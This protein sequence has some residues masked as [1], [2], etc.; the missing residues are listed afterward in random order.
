MTGGAENGTSPPTAAWTPLK[1]FT[2]NTQEQYQRP[3]Q[4]KNWP[5]CYKVEKDDAKKYPQR[6]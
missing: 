1:K 2:G 4:R 3:L 6:L 5:L